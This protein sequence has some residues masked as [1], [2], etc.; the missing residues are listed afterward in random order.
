[1]R[2]IKCHEHAVGFAKR[3]WS[4]CAASSK[5]GHVGHSTEGFPTGR[6]MVQPVLLSYRDQ[7]GGAQVGQVF[8][9]ETFLLF[10]NME[11]M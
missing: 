8:N 7:H 4:A 11:D 3:M 6:E 2:G 5:T 10:G 9:V 1:M